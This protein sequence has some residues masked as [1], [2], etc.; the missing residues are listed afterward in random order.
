MAN[1]A[2]QGNAAAETWNLQAAIEVATDEVDGLAA[3]APGCVAC[4]ALGSGERPAGGL[5]AFL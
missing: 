1:F 3:S 2:L 4:L 5:F